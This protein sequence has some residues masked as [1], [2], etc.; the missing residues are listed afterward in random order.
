MSPRPCLSFFF[1]VAFSLQSSIG[2][3]RRP[4]QTEN[5]TKQ[6]GGRVVTDF[7]HPLLLLLLLLLLF[8]T[9][10]KVVFLFCIA[11]VCVA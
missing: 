7:G 8:V 9:S 1:F 11:I 2:N 5:K 10:F 6:K 4:A 3:C